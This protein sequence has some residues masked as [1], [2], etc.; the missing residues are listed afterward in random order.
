VQTT[1]RLDRRFVLGSI[2]VLLIGA[3]VTAML[4][5]WLWAPLGVLTALLLLNAL[6][7]GVWPPV[8]ARTDDEGA[9]L[10]GPGTSK[11][12]TVAWSEVEDVSIE[13]GRLV[14]DLGDRSIVFSLAYLG[15]RGN[16][17]VQDVYERLNAAN[18]YRRFD[19]SA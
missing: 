4:A 2:G 7:V 11:P 17:F 13:G 5:F 9:R 16:E 10:G 18:G 19:P 8:V 15:A 1:Y 6:R 12:M 3:G 14:F